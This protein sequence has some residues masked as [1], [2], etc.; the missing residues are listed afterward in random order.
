MMENRRGFPKLKHDPG[1]PTLQTHSREKSKT[2]AVSSI[3]K[4]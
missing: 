2:T 3:G 1:V 4:Q